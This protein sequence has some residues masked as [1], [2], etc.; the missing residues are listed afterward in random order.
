MF[1][2]PSDDECPCLVGIISGGVLT[3]GDEDEEDVT[4]E[5]GARFKD[6]RGRV[7]DLRGL[8]PRCVCGPC[9]FLGESR[10]SKTNADDGDIGISWQLLSDKSSRHLGLFFK[11]EYTL[12]VSLSQF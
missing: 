10:F 3:D 7:G 11:Y 8:N 5:T 2:K 12:E 4:M 1:W 9:N 6:L